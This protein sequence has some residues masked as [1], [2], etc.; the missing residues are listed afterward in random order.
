MIREAI[1]H[2]VGGATLSTEEAAAA[3]EEIMTGEATSA[4]I[5]AF[6]TALR[7]RPHGETI[8]EIAGLAQV[9]RDKALPV[10]LNMHA[11]AHAMDTCGTGGDGSGTLNISTA[12]GIIAAA[13]GATIAK[14]GNRSATSKSGSADVLEALGL[15]IDLAPEALAKSIETCGFGFMFAQTYHPAMKYVGAT[16]GEIGIRTV[17]NILGPLTN[18]AHTPY[19]V[20]GVADR[21]HLR[22]M[23]AVLLHMGCKHALIVHS[24]DGL[25]ECSLSA[26]THICEV[27]AG[28]ELR[29]YTITPEEVGLTSVTNRKHF[30]GGNPIYN[31]TALR[32]ILSTYSATP[33]TDMICLNA[34]AALMAN[35][36]VSSFQEGIKLARA[37]LQEGKAKRKL[38]EVIEFSQTYSR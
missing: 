17:F 9:M 14:H 6:L 32:D 19:Q 28:Q 24:E 34:A 18:P 26:P 16:R 8:D 21:S 11:A 20:L 1:A 23:G 13:A 29:E 37:T 35:E 2:I 22:K 31:A 12:A 38:A 27:R 3:M 36:Q 10:H 30:Q 4:Q 33:A 5:G 7:M 25:D 15:K